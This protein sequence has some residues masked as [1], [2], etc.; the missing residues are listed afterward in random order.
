MISRRPVS[1]AGSQ[2]WLGPLAC[3]IASAPSIARADGPYE[4]TWREGP[5]SIDVAVTSWGGDCGPQPQSTSTPGGGTFQI[6]QEGDQLTFQMRRQ[7]TTRGC[8]SENRA[9]RRV[10]STAQAGT[11][12]I[13]CRTPPED[14]RGETGTYTVQAVGDDRLTFRDVS[15][16]DWQL[17]ASR[18]RATITTTQAFTRVSAAPAPSEPTREETPACTPG[19]A[20]RI[21]L[22]PGTAD[23]TPGGQECFTT[24][25]V[26]AAGCAVRAQRVDLELAEGAGSLEGRCYRASS[27][28]GVARI[29]ARAGAL[30][31][32]ARVTVRA[33]D[34]SDLI[35]RR[36]E[37]GS[38]GSS[39]D[40]DATATADT[41][42]RVSTRNDGEALD[43][44]WPA[45]GLGV[46]LLLVI[47]GAIALIRR[48]KPSGIAGLPGVE[49]LESEPVPPPPEERAAPEAP[50]SAA[51]VPEPAGRR[52]DLIC[53]TC[54][55]G[56]PPGTAI[57]TH[58]DTP[59][60]PYREFIARAD[61]DNVCPVCGERYPAHIKFCGK[62][63]ATLKATSS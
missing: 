16:Y 20:A 62:D 46:A 15:Q 8:W 61:R 26:D 5:M 28:D 63:G 11:W 12:R 33:V 31:S 47:G 59:L 58:D 17:N 22:R 27:A 19:E 9:V 7:R 35:A 21:V 44:R 52:E 57:C 41:A 10:S 50:V 6:A 24:R 38:V 32:E 40:T 43:W 37:T 1:R 2:R 51:A 42:A 3:A 23:V 4:G 25:V 29:V 45:L 54:R 39:T 13:V 18:C 30:T 48:R 60:V 49:I 14:S 53:P 55:R 36:T 56:Y 34:L